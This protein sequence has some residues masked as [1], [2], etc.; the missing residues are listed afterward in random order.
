M[1]PLQPG[2]RSARKKTLPPLM[3]MY[4]G[5]SPPPVPLSGSLLVAVISRDC[6]PDR[7]SDAAIEATC[8]SWCLG[9]ERVQPCTGMPWTTGPLLSILMIDDLRVST[10]PAIS[11]AA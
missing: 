5:T 4:P 11:E 7:A 8:T 10:F 3:E 1:R 2:E 6:S 9:G